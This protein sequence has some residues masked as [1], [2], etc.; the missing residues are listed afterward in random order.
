VRRI[1]GLVSLVAA[2]L[3]TSAC[4]EQDPRLIDETGSVTEFAFIMGPDLSASV[5]SEEIEA[6]G[7]GAVA[8]E[9]PEGWDIRV[10][11]LTGS[12][13]RSPTVRVTGADGRITAIH[14]DYGRAPVGECPSD[15]TIYAV[16]LK[17]SRSPAAD[18]TVTGG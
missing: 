18:L 2:F 9:H 7:T 6:A 16:D 13:Y 8:V 1:A 14:V 3:L 4:S 12:C 17:V 11:W 10:A 5:S 15:L